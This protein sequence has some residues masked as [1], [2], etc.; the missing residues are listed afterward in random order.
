MIEHLTN[1]DGFFQNIRRLLAPGGILIIST[2]NP[3]Y[4][5]EF[6]Y[7]AFK[8]SIFQNPEH[9]CWIDPQSMEQLLGRFCF[10]VTML[11]LIKDTRWKLKDFISNAVDNRFDILQSRW[12]HAGLFARAQRKALGALFSLYYL[13]FFLCIRNPLVRYADY[14]VVAQLNTNNHENS[15]S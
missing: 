9:T 12:S 3:F 5:E 2:C 4:R 15:R 6:F 7:T 14:L 1:I 10:Q 11:G 8:N 13:P